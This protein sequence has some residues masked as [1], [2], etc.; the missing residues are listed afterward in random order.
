MSSSSSSSAAASTT[1]QCSAC[2]LPFPSKNQLFKHLRSSAC[3]LASE[4]TPDES[5]FIKV[6]IIYGYYNDAFPPISSIGD[7]AA[8][9]ILRTIPKINQQPPSTPTPTSSRSFGISSRTSPLLN[10]DTIIAG[11]LSEVLSVKLSPFVV[12]SIDSSSI[13]QQQLVSK[14]N[15][16][17]QT[18]LAAT[19]PKAA[20]TIQ[21]F[22][23]QTV[24]KTFNAEAH[25][26]SRSAEVL[27][28]YEFFADST[29]P[30]GPLDRADFATGVSTGEYGER[31]TMVY[32]ENPT[33]DGVG[34]E[35]PTAKLLDFCVALKKVAQQVARP[36][37]EKAIELERGG[38][39]VEPKKKKAKNETAGGSGNEPKTG[40]PKT[41]K[42]KRTR[43]HNFSDVALQNDVVAN[44]MIYRFFQKGNFLLQADADQQADPH[45]FLSLCVNSDMFMKV[46]ERALEQFLRCGA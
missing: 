24:D 25:C 5:T 34:E 13:S 10:Q 33:P 32:R 37:L 44:R 14:L 12:A 38:A 19:K 18:E 42:V 16:L 20:L 11:A 46:S 40:E 8:S 6:A 22:G 39:N 17:L 2:S 9:L 29:S 30:L 31:R 26:T 21:I 7:L 45:P 43:L 4:L 3:G 1:I 28:P 41:G 36:N 27:V 23:V 35:E 15:I